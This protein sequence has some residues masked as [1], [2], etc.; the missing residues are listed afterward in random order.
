MIVGSSSVRRLFLVALAAGPVT[1][2]A[3]G[4]CGSDSS[5]SNPT[6]DAGVGISLE[7]GSSSPPDAEA[8]PPDG[9]SDAPSDAPSGLLAP[10]I[11]T[12]KATSAGVLLG[13]T[14]R[15]PDCDFIVGERKTALESYAQKFSVPG[16][17]TQS[18][19]TTSTNVPNAASTNCTYRLICKKGGAVS[20]YSNEMTTSCGP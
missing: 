18:L 1:G 10:L 11:D 6:T 3:V 14:N 2:L 19:D 12:I 7:S 15:T 20:P 16:T 9:G 17:T 8:S 13:W 4:A 5:P